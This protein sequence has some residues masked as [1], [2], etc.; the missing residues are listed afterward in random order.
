MT[1]EA[2][3]QYTI[4]IS[5]L[6]R[7]LRAQ[8]DAPVSASVAPDVAP[9]SAPRRPKAGRPRRP[10]RAGPAIAL[11][12]DGARPFRFDGWPLA[13]FQLETPVTEAVTSQ[14]AARAFNS[15]AAGAGAE[16]LANGG[17]AVTHSLDLYLAQDGA[18]IAQL[19]L[20]VP[21]GCPARPLHR[22]AELRSRDDLERFLSAHR[23]EDAFCAT[24]SRRRGHADRVAN[25]LATLRADFARLTAP[26][27]PSPGDL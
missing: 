18:V 22:V 23:P 2:Q 11:R 17:G 26:L 8:A 14:T 9:R 3:P 5:P 10:S 25:I 15:A 16:A 19:R 13:S 1:T 27:R 7:S 6:L 20:D 12:Q 4:R 21:D 24:A